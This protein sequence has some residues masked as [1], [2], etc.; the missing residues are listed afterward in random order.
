V[1]RA[2]KEKKIPLRLDVNLMNT[3]F[4]LLAN[5]NY[6]LNIQHAKKFFLIQ[7]LVHLPTTNFSLICEL[8][9]F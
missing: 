6:L 4:F 8:F 5:S 2:R 3:E 1:D 7:L 9:L